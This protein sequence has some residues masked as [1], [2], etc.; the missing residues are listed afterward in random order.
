MEILTSKC[1]RGVSEFL[2]SWFLTHSGMGLYF[3]TETKI[4]KNEK[5]KNEEK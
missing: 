2:S 4:T 1:P 3:H 5:E